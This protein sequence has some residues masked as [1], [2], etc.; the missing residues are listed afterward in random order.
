VLLN[1]EVFPIKSVPSGTD[2][3]IE[4][5]LY[6]AV[7]D[8]RFGDKV[9]FTVRLET[10]INDNDLI[11]PMVKILYNRNNTIEEYLM[12]LVLQEV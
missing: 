12:P 7:N 4:T 5:I 8:F 2:F 11:F 3:S 10:F 9:S 6:N 1:N